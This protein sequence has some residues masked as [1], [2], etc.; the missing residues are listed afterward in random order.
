MDSIMGRIERASLPRHLL[1]IELTERQLLLGSGSSVRSLERLANAGV[2]LS[3]DDFGTGTSSLAALRHIPA[4]ELKIDKSFVDD[5]RTGD[6]AL[7][8]SIVNMAH[9]LGLEVVA[10]G[11]EDEVTWRWLRAH[12]A[13]HAQGYYFAR[14]APAAAIEPLLAGAPLPWRPNQAAR[15]VD[16]A[17]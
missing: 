12:G 4:H 17:G 3:V 2:W 13:D 1:G 7:I 10:E 9:Q 5:L 16:P 11:V 15:S 8:G 6:S 14:P